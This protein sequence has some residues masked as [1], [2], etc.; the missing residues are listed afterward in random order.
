MTQKIP[1]AVIGVGYLG[2]IHARIYHSMPQVDLVAVVD[3]DASVAEA[4]AKECECEAFTSIDPILDRVQAVSIVVPTSLHGTVA[5]PFLD[6]GVHMLMEK[7]IAPS[8]D[9]SL[10]LVERAREAGVIFQVGHLERFNAGVKALSERVRDPRFIEAHRMSPFVARA[11]DV[12]VVTDLMIHDIDIVL[13]LVKSEVVSVQAIG[14]PVLTHHVDIANARLE[15]ANGAAANLTASRVSEKRFR[16][17]RVFEKHCYEALNF[18]DQQVE[19]MRAV[20][21]AEDGEWPEIVKE[22][23]AV[24]AQQPLDAELAAFIHSVNSGEPPLVD[25][26]VALEALRVAMTVKEMMAARPS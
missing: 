9:E 22:N 15:F 18:V 8:Y 26:H 2:R 23:L 13:S 11:T 19:V 16:R 3:T 20:P 10:H 6:R 5:A 4:V 7:P 21:A 24:D 14:L 17:V 1:V 12:D 25:G